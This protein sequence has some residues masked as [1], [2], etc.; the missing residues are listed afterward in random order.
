MITYVYTARNINTGEQ[1]KAEVQ[2]ESDKAAAKLLMA[3]SLVPISIEAK[4][5]PNSILARFSN[6]VGAKDTIL[7]TRQLSTLIN[8]GLPLT[9]SLRTVREQVNNKML[10]GI[11][12]QVIS[13]VEGGSSLADAF[14]KHPKVFNQIYVSLIAAGEASGSLDKSLERIAD[15]QEKDHAL[16]SK[17]RSAMIYPAIVLLVIVAVLLFML[18][19]VLPQIEQLYTDLGKDLPLLTAVLV[20]VAKIV[21]N[22]W[23]LIIILGAG[24]AV[25]LRRWMKTPQ[26]R[27]AFDRFKMRV[28]IFG[29]LFRKLYMARFCRTASVLLA[30]GLPMLEMLRIVQGTINNVHIEAAIERAST[31]VKGGKALSTAL[32]KEPDFLLLVPQMLK[33]GEQSGTIDQMMSKTATFYE[34]ELD[35]AVKNISTTIEPFLMI[36]L[37]ITV[38]IIVAAILLPVYGLI[39]FDLSGA[40]GGSSGGTGAP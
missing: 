33:I 27:S 39:N 30:S 36:A 37:G 17:L 12:N 25:A 28:P 18:T 9:Q 34:N 3:Q 26:G 40:S 8:A 29:N 16:I 38:G 11:I 14:G 13:D 10:L 4:D 22:F 6:R 21:R 19:T 31:K 15:Q 32:E 2:A 5:Q 7:F 23:W 1:V 20:S 35:T 24:G